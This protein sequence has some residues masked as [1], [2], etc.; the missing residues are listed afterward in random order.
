M[1]VHQNSPVK[2]EVRSAAQ[3][4]EGILTAAEADTLSV[5]EAA[6]SIEQIY[7]QQDPWSLL[8]ELTV[9]HL[10]HWIIR[11]WT[12]SPYDT[13][14]CL[15]R[16]INPLDMPEARAL[17]ETECLIADV[18]DQALIKS[19]LQLPQEDIYVWLWM[20]LKRLHGRVLDTIQDVGSHPFLP[21]IALN[22][23]EMRDSFEY[24]PAPPPVWRRCNYPEWSTRKIITDKLERLVNYDAS[25]AGSDLGRAILATIDQ[26][27]TIPDRISSAKTQSNTPRQD[28]G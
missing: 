18:N 24:Q 15:I 25:F 11:S 17:L 1:P 16:L 20:S 23:V 9:Q 13:Q 8:P 7:Y 26:Y 14:R 12:Q 28:K 22:L 2:L 4:I 21:F 5:A 3:A 10:E 27:L 6:G 19:L